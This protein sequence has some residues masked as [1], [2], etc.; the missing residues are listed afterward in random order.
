MAFDLQEQEQIDSMKAFWHQY[1]KWLAA[2]FAALVLAYLGYKG[3]GMY[4]KDQ[5]RDAAQS[6]AELEKKI[7]AG[8]LDGVRKATASIETTYGKTPY[9]ARAA[10]LAARLGFDRNDTAFARAQLSWAA[11]HAS[12]PGIKAVA[13]LRLAGL[14]LDQKNFPAALAALAREHDAAFD[15]EFLDMKGDV[16]LAKGDKPAARD[17]YKSAVAKLPGDSPSRQFIQTKLEALG[18]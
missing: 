3:W 1:G 14:E 12:E 18:G 11:E 17:A 13:L 5:V 10:L 7:I 4:Q 6:Y 9:G 2:L 16:Q 8:D 15:A